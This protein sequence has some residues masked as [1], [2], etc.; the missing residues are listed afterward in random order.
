MGTVAPPSDIDCSS[1]PPRVTIV[2]P[3]FKQEVFLFECLN[4][5]IAQTMSTWEAVVVDDCSPARMVD[6]IVG[7]YN[8]SRIRSIRLDT[9]RGLAASRN[10]GLQAGRAPLVLCIDADDFLHP[11]FLSTTVDTIERRGADCAYTDFQLVGLSN[12]LWTWELK[13]PDELAKKQFIPGPGVLM[14]RSVW[15]RVGGYSEEL[16]WNEDW[17]FWI[18]A[19]HMGFSFE[20]VPRPLYFYRRHP[21]SMLT[22]FRT[23]MSDWMTR[24]VI[25]KKRAGFFA[26]GD[27]STTFQTGGLLTSARANRNPGISMASSYINGSRD[28]NQPKATF[29]RIQSRD[30]AA[31]ERSTK[32]SKGEQS[33]QFGKW[34]D[35]IFQT[36]QR[37]VIVP[38]R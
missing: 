38:R 3:C 33:R 31:I 30:P 10:T 26:V 22:G 11:E 20:R 27:R 24:E 13:S 12:D 37:M 34:S 36:A 28:C 16:R 21:D 17:D 15:E 6:Q 14:R 18:G 8:N 7:T 9:N 35:D 4:S 29:E 32:D 23:R 25:L 2:I 19:M 1:G 5:L